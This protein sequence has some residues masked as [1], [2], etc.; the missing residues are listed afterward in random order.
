MKFDEFALDV[1]GIDEKI[2]VEVHLRWW[3]PVYVGVMRFLVWIFQ[4]E[5]NWERAEYWIDRGIYLAVADESMPLAKR[6][7]EERKAKQQE[8]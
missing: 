5:P 4:Q 1:E 8:K 2:I 6:V 3:L 7:I